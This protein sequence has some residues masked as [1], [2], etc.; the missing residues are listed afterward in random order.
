MKPTYLSDIHHSDY[1]FSHGSRLVYGCSGLG[2]V[3]GET[4]YDESVDCLLYAFEN[5]ITSLDTSPSYNHSETVVGRALAQWKGPRPF[6]STKVGRLKSENAYHTVVDYSR[7]RMHRSLQESLET[8]GVDHVDLLFLHEPYLVPLERMEE[9]LDTLKSFV[10]AGYT[11]LIGVG[12]NPT[13][14]F[15]PFITYENFQVISGFLKLDACNFSA[16]DKDLPHA[17]QEGVAYYAASALHF[18]LLGNRYDQFVNTPPNDGWISE[19]D[20]ENA[21]RVKAIADREGMKLSSLAQRFLFS[22]KEASRVVM[23]ARKNEQ[24]RS[25]LDDW[26]AGVLP[27]ALFNEI[28]ENVY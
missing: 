19:K 9:V 22:T 14:G 24:I 7:E 25:T 17:Q 2:G 26:K 5:G 23:G 28:V 4:N 1:D 27:E 12:G 10:D 6:I 20:I 21:K 3:W 13:D 18:S 11:R 16:F 8:L 15:R